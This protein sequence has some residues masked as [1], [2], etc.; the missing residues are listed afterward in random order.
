MGKEKKRGII[1]KMQEQIN[2]SSGANMDKFY[3]KDGNEAK[4]RFLTDFEEPTEVPFHYVYAQNRDESINEPCRL[5]MGDNECEHCDN[6]VNI[7]HMYVWPIWNYS[8]D[9]Q[10]IL[11]FAANR[12]SPIP[13][14]I[15]LYEEYSTLMDRD[16]KISRVGSQSNTTYPVLPLDKGRFKG[17]AKPFSKSKIVKILEDS[18]FADADFNPEDFDEDGDSDFLEELQELDKKE[19][20]QVAK[21]LKV[22]RKDYKE[23]KT[24]KKRIKFITENFSDDDIEEALE[25]SV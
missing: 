19:L 20:M 21:Y 14:L 16:I 18:F 9:K 7:R 23:L 6:D 13:G 22:P 15:A 2:Q 4:V 10:Q 11:L 17:K 24:S 5:F 3:L 8:Q 25:E 1:G 12:C